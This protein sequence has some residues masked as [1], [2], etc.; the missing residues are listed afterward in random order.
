VAV[1]TRRRICP[2]VRLGARHPVQSERSAHLGLGITACSALSRAK[3]PQWGVG[4]A[5]S[6]SAQRTPAVGQGRGSQLR[7]HVRTAP[8]NRDWAKLYRPRRA[9]FLG[10]PAWRNRAGLMEPVRSVTFGSRR[11]WT[12]TEAESALRDGR[13]RRQAALSVGSATSLNPD[14]S[15]RRLGFVLV[16][17]KPLGAVSSARS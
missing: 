13:A 4:E 3:K 7:R 14:G 1:V 17:D 2:A 10:T 12:T 5:H 8:F 6:L 9:A 11:R 16:C 15:G